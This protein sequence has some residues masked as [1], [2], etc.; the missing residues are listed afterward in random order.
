MPNT[1]D[2]GFARKL[3]AAFDRVDARGM[4]E[5]YYD[6]AGDVDPARRRVQI[7]HILSAPARART[8]LDAIGPIGEG[9][10]LD[11]G[12]GSGSFLAAAAGAEPTRVDRR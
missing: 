8:W 10:V 4:L 3:D 7:D 1:E 9:P 5:L 6:T 2:S 12:C 11:L